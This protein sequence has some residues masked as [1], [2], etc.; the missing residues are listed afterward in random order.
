M[1][2]LHTPESH[3]LFSREHSAHLVGFLEILLTCWQLGI[4]IGLQGFLTRIPERIPPKIHVLSRWAD[5]FFSVQLCGKCIPQDI[6]SYKGFPWPSSFGWGPC[7]PG[8]LQKIPHVWVPG[9][10]CAMWSLEDVNCQLGCQDWSM[11]QVGTANVAAGV[12][13]DYHCIRWWYNTWCP[14]EKNLQM[15]I[16]WSPKI[17][18]WKRMGSGQASGWRHWN[19]SWVA[20]INFCCERMYWEQGQYFGLVVVLDHWCFKSVVPKTCTTKMWSYQ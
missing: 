7:T 11:L 12:R 4:T 9:R 16:N 6:S 17:F 18:N 5:P 10:N 1:T 13:H 15:F 2:D 19:P 3:C 8:P 20:V 14:S